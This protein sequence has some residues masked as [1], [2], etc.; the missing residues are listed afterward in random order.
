MVRTEVFE[1]RVTQTD[2]VWH[3]ALVQNGIT[4][5]SGRGANEYAARARLHFALYEDFRR[6]HELTHD[7]AVEV[8]E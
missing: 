7:D 5:A 8:D 4:V 2:S 1:L 6:L 3:I